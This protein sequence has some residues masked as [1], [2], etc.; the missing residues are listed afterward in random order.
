MTRSRIT[1]IPLPGG[2]CRVP[3]GALQFED[4]WP[5]LFIRGDEAL[6]LMTRIRYL[7]E[8]LGNQTDP[9]IISV[10]VSLTKLA[11]LV[12]RDVKMQS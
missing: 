9:G 7:V 2:S 3:T 8:R 11:D 12:E 4:D 10:I 1:Q 5:G 6:F